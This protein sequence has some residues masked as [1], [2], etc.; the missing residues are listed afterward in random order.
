M[1]NLKKNIYFQNETK[2]EK[3]FNI[4]FPLVALKLSFFFSFHLKN[5][6]KYNLYSSYTQWLLSFSFF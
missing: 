5:K 1:L 4:L 2:C 6:I 3:V